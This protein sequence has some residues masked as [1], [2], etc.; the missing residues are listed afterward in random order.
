MTGL[1]VD[2]F[3]LDGVI[4]A[5]AF[6]VGGIH[7][8][9]LSHL[10]LFLAAGFAGL[11]EDGLGDVGALIHLDVSGDLDCPDGHCHE[12]VDSGVVVGVGAVVVIFLGFKT[13]LFGHDNFKLVGIFALYFGA[14]VVAGKFVV[15]F[16]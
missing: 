14:V 5:A 11:G 3:G 13:T 12:L 1:A 10:S 15:A 8:E 16:L 2:L 7:L 6:I 4:C 9:S